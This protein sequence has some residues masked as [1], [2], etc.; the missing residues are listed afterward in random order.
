MYVSLV[1]IHRNHDYRP[2]FKA[3]T[4][5]WD[6]SLPIS[7]PG[8][9]LKKTPKLKVILACRS[10]LA[11]KKKHVRT[12]NLFPPKLA[13]GSKC[14][15]PMFSFHQAGQQKSLDFSCSSRQTINRS[16]LAPLF[17]GNGS[18]MMKLWDPQPQVDG[19]EG[20][21]MVGPH[22]LHHAIS[23]VIYPGWERAKGRQGW[24]MYFPILNEE[25]FRTPRLLK[26]AGFLPNEA[27][28]SVDIT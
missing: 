12:C 19:W 13:C 14:Q 1:G 22:A 8:F 3:T 2:S 5:R 23:F 15:V 10:N 20:T 7:V 18:G 26:I 11:E 25:L 24:C 17:L 16:A 9:F 6:W 21:K 27:V 4:L 28:D